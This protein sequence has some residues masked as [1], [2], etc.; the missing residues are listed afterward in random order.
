MLGNQARAGRRPARAWFNNIATTKTKLVLYIL[1]CNNYYY[2]SVV[3]VHMNT[4]IV[5]VVLY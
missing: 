4:H 1:Y 2:A 3:T 5:A